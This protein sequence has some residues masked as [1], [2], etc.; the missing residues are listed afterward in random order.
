MCYTHFRHLSRNPT[1]LIFLTET[2]LLKTVVEVETFQ[3]S[4][5]NGGSEERVP[6]LQSTP[7]RSPL[8]WYRFRGKGSRQ[9][10]TD[11]VL[12][13]RKTYIE[14]NQYIETKRRNRLINVCYV[15]FLFFRN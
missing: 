13:L 3:G 9:T 11:L 10:F 6:D 8:Q 5:T 15:P 1:L 12:V 2:N 14:R 7:D 4:V